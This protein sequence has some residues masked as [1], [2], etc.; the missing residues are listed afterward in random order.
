[1]IANFNGTDIAF[2]DRGTGAPLVALHG[3]LSAAVMWEPLYRA[4]PDVRFI[5]PD[6]PGHGD[7]AD[8]LPDVHS[9]TT[10]AIEGLIDM[11]PGPVDLVGH[12]YGG[13]I[14]L[15]IAVESPDRVR[16]LTLIEPVFF[17]AAPERHRQKYVEHSEPQASAMGRG[18][19]TEAARLFLADWGLNMSWDTMPAAH[20]RYMTE[21]MP[22]VS[23]TAETILD[24][25]HGLLLPGRL[26]RADMPV[27][28]VEGTQT[29]PIIEHIQNGLAARLSNARRVVFPGAGH[30]VPFTH[31]NS[32]S[33]ELR[34]LL[35]LV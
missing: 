18:D 34:R 19:W 32:L 35:A 17:A 1:M 28:L 7:S 22:I 14:A 5:A 11:T 12:S 27:L 23:A 6:L 30:T 24:D 4:L 3:A 31:A 16:S 10:R 15:R 21:R 13:T 26:E 20:R 2:R 29:M 9:Q 33:H 8:A 25:I